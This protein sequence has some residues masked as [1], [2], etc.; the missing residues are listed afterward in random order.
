[1]N[2]SNH[3]TPEVPTAVLPYD[4]HGVQVR[5]ITRLKTRSGVRPQESVAVIDREEGAL[6]PMTSET[7]SQENH[8]VRN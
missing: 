7:Y 4:L 3:L 1:M 8:Q 6:V 5:H 2:N